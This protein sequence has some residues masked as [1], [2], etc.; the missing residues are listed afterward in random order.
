MSIEEHETTV[1]WDYKDQVVRI[2]TTREG[3]KNGFLKRL[4]QDK[5]PEVKG[6]GPW[7]FVVPFAD[8]RAP[9]L[10]A[11]LLNPDERTP[12]SE[13]QKAALRAA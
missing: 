13:G 11:K 4:G 3:V 10:I 6:S 9:Q 2:Y 7:S 8:C 12:M 1:T 5:S